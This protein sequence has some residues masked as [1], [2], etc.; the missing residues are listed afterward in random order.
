[1]QR[2]VLIVPGI[3]N[4]G[5][6][7]WQSLWQQAEPGWR[8][9]RV[10]DWEQVQAGDWVAALERDV[11][12]LGAGVVLVAHSLGCLA[13]AQWATQSE[14]AAS[15]AGA[16]LVAP[17]DPQAAA[18]PAQQARSFLPAG[19]PLPFPALVLASSDDPYAAIERARDMARAWAAELLE[20]GPRG[21]LNAASGLGEWP[22]GR[23]LLSRFGA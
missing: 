2:P 15:V 1:M 20:L 7:H 5:P 23:A 21:H 11:A 12:E 22:Q 10:P 17:P 4:S 16:L 8:R 13:V 19:A 14:L 3:G 9:L 6:Q 18:F